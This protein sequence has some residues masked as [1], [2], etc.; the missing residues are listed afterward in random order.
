MVSQVIFIVGKEW[1][2]PDVK[3]KRHECLYFKTAYNL[4]ILILI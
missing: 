4:W 2:I 1:I 3:D